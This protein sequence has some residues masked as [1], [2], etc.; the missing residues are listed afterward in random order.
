MKTSASLCN[1]WALPLFLQVTLQP[2]E[3]TKWKYTILSWPIHCLKHQCFHAKLK[4][5]RNQSKFCSC[6][7]DFFEI[8][9]NSKIAQSSTVS[10]STFCFHLTYVWFTFPLTLYVGI[11]LLPFFPKK[12]NQFMGFLLQKDPSFFC[13]DFF[14]HFI[15]SSFFSFLSELIYKL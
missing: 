9:E 6:L 14:H 4:L 5:L 15:S 3:T 7:R 13:L 8:P 2:V 10:P 1:R 11:L 12:V